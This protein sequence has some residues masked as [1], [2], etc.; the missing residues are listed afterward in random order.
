MFFLLPA[1]LVYV[2]SH[3]HIYESIKQLEFG[4]HSHSLSLYPPTTD[5]PENFFQYSRVPKT[6]VVGLN[7]T[8]NIF[9]VWKVFSSKYT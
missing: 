3:I 6:F 2:C 9:V 8:W 1:K 4:F 7:S 5:L